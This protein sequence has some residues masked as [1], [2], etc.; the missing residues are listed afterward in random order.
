M[1]KNLTKIIKFL[2][3]LTAAMVEI[4]RQVVDFTRSFVWRHSIL[5]VR[6]V[7]LLSFLPTFFKPFC[8]TKALKWKWIQV[9]ELS[10]LNLCPKTLTMSNKS[11]WQYGTWQQILRLAFVKQKFVQQ[12]RCYLYKYQPNSLLVK[13]KG[14]QT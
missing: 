14:L 1:Q 9:S 7:R 12:M 5:P 8:C 6:F 11:H 13:K 3:N 10:S 2:V 4:T